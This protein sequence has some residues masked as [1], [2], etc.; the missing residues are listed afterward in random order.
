LLLHLNP[1]LR[2]EMLRGNVD[3]RLRKQRE[4]IVDAIVLAAA[5][6]MRL[7]LTPVHSVTLDRQVFLPAIGQGALAVETRR[8]DEAAELVRS[9]NHETTAIAVGAERALLRRVGGN[10]R[11]PLA[12]H[13]TVRNGVVHLTALVASPDGRHV[14]CGEHT[15]RSGEAEQIGA[16][17]AETLLAQGGREI[18]QSLSA[19]I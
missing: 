19:V 6:L 8:D 2:V 16:V 1:G 7:G 11:T 9:L 18:L 3:T 12:A 10:C 5:G 4:G 15:G 13:A 17:L 14:I